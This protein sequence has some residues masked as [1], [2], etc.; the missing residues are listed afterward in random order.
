MTSLHWPVFG[1]P[2]QIQAVQV[3]RPPHG[4]PIGQGSA[5]STPVWGMCGTRNV[6]PSFAARM[7]P[8]QLKI[9]FDEHTS[10][11]SRVLTL[12]SPWINRLGV[13][14]P[15]ARLVC[16]A[17]RCGLWPS[18]CQSVRGSA[19]ELVPT[20]S[21]SSN[22]HRDGGNG[23]AGKYGWSKSR[24][25]LD[26]VPKTWQRSSKP[27][28]TALPAA[29]SAGHRN[30]QTQASSEQQSILDVLAARRPSGAEAASE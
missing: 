17:K 28:R 8:Q 12:P 7:A 13:E 20:L 2:I 23:S 30:L 4:H 21:S 6:R 10:Y 16:T 15:G 3:G 5:P 26:S 29:P 11:D 14:I 22:E 19:C 18:A 24:E 27:D 9:G 25:A 1:V